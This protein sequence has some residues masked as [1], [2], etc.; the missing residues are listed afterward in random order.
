ME[1]IAD[2]SVQLDPRGASNAER[3][4][5]SAVSS[6]HRRRRPLIVLGALMMVISALVAAWLVASASETHRV[7]VANGD[8]EPGQEIGE[9]D[10][11]VVEVGGGLQPS[12][13]PADEQDRV[14]GRFP[15]AR[16][17]S[18]TLLN[19]AMFIDRGSVI[20]EGHVVVGAVLRPGQV[21]VEGLA[22]GDV[23]ELITTAG[24][25][26]GQPATS[27]AIGTVFSIASTDNGYWVAVE[28][29]SAARLAVASAAASEEL[30]LGMVG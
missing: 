4:P 1:L 5:I 7:V 14:L 18:G 30:S 2:S 27:I 13:I 29:E 9:A 17:P 3:V 15:A 8:L 19:E 10:L 23:V 6:P 24:A 25:D 21:P 28:I 11:V 12:S 26:D 20:P 22:A 16:I